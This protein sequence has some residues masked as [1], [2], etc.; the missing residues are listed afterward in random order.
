VAI[1]A[2]L[3]LKEELHFLSRIVRRGVR[4]KQDGS[5]VSPADFDARLRELGKRRVRDACARNGIVAP[6]S[7]GIE[8]HRLHRRAKPCATPSA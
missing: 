5:A 6:K 2:P 3:T 1:P 7:F 8:M 4:A